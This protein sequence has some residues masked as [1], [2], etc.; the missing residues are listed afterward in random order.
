MRRK[1]DMWKDTQG[2]FLPEESEQEAQAAAVDARERIHK[3]EEQLQSQFTSMATYAEIAQRAVDTAR[4]EARADLER[5]K[6]T[7]VSLMER[8]R[9]E[10]L[11][12]DHRPVIAATLP[13]PAPPP[14]PEPVGPLID[15]SALARI[16]LLEDRFER[17]GYQF[18]Q[19]LKSQ[20]E[21]ANSIAFM[22]EQQLRASSWSQEPALSQ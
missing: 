5:E 3:L 11:D 6:S 13:T 10:L 9:L 21:L 7:L 17:L 4:A 19:V 12:D 1:N 22:F 20:E 16:A 15:I 18:G 14:P 2:S 8:I